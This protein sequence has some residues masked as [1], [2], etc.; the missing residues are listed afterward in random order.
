[1]RG[2]PGVYVIYIEY[3]GRMVRTGVDRTGTYSYRELAGI[4]WI[5]LKPETIKVNGKR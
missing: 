4:F 1:M 3:E 2:I 5:F